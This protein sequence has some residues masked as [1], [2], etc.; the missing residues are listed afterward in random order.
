MCPGGQAELVYAGEAWT[1]RAPVVRLCARHKG[2]CKMAIEVRFGHFMALVKCH[3][4][5]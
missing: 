4:A 2:F 3:E 5:D 1:R